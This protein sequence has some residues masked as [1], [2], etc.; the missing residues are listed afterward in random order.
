MTHPKDQD[1]PLGQERKEKK[2]KEDE[3][4]IEVGDTCTKVNPL[5]SNLS[6]LFKEVLEEVHPDVA[7]S[8]KKLAKT[9]ATQF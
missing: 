6:F 4:E 1:S 2:R 8:Y 5:V 7:T 9:L 3:G